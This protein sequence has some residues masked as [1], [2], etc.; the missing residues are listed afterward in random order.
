MVPGGK[1]TSVV[2]VTQPVRPALE[3]GWVEPEVAHRHGKPLPTGEG[4][5]D[6]EVFDPGACVEG[7]FQEA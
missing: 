6:M 1:P 7:V 2:V 3:G 5:D 4:L